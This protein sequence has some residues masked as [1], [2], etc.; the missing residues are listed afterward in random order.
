M[1]RKEPPAEFVFGQNVKDRAKVCQALQPPLPAGMRSQIA[2]LMA[3]CVCMCV[4]PRDSV[5]C[6]CV[7][8][9]V[10]GRL[11]RVVRQ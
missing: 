5:L 3:T 10:A 6:V 4:C 11:Q 8:V 2:G 7:S 9:C 1:E